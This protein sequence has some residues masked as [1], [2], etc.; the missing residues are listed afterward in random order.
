MQNCALP[1]PHDPISL[2]QLFLEG[3]SK[4]KLETEAAKNSKHLIILNESNSRFNTNA[5]VHQSLCL[6]EQDRR[7]QRDVIA[8]ESCTGSKTTKA[9]NEIKLSQ[10]FRG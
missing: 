7:A 3:E 4:L 10:V 2:S 6:I 8:T 5:N 9:T 1:C